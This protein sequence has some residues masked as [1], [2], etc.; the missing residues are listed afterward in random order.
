MSVTEG[1]RH[2]IARQLNQV[3]LEQA[4]VE[5]GDSLEDLAEQYDVQS[6]KAADAEVN[7]KL[8][9]YRTLLWVKANGLTLTSD[10]GQEVHH[11]KVTEKLSEAYAVATADRLFRDY[12]VTARA[13]EATKSAVFTRQA[14]L[15]SLRTL[16]ANVRS[17]T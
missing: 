16:S 9:Y 1:P 2:R 10:D 7:Y 8:A 15:E 17:Q 3:E 12:K 4:I 11:P 13:A 14:R 6:E 5:L